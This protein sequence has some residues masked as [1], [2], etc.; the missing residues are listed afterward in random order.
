MGRAERMGPVQSESLWWNRAMNRVMPLSTTISNTASAF[1]RPDWGRE[2]QWL[3]IFTA[4]SLRSISAWLST[5]NPLT[6]ET[7]PV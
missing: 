3:S 7:G 2:L 5:G 6:G 4:T 1:S